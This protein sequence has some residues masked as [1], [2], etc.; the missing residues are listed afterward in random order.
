MGPA[1]GKEIFGQGF[2]GN[3]K[4]LFC[5]YGDARHFLRLW[6]QRQPK[7]A[8]SAQAQTENNNYQGGRCGE[9][10]KIDYRDLSLACR[11]MRTR[12]QALQCKGLS[13]DFLRKYPAVNCTAPERNERTGEVT[14]RRIE[15]REIEAILERLRRIGV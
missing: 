4:N 6:P 8:T 15:A 5:L 1:S 2:W 3:E 10:V 12:E 9:K 13:Q 7:V 14:E 11:H